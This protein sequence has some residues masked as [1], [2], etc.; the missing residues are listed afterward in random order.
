MIDLGVGERQVEGGRDEHG[1]GHSVL[2]VA[3]QNCGRQGDLAPGGIPGQ[4][5]TA[6]PGGA[7]AH[8]IRDRWDDLVGGPERHQR[9]DGYGHTRPRLG[10]DLSG[11]LP[12]LHHDLVHPPAAVHVDDTSASLASLGRERDR[13]ASPVGGRRTPTR[14]G[15]IGAAGQN[16]VV[17]SSAV[18][19]AFWLRP[20]WCKS[21]SPA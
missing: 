5:G 4:T 14:P 18:R 11:E 7:G 3:Q 17:E 9:V 21:D 1:A 8:E 19:C 13:P 6:V 15:A 16:G 10:G 20:D 2:S 12:V